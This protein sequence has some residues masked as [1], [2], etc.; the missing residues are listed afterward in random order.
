MYLGLKAGGSFIGSKSE[1]ANAPGVFPGPPDIVLKGRTFG[2]GSHTKGTFALGALMGYDFYSLYDK[3]VRL[4]LDYT[5]RSSVDYGKK[6]KTVL[7]ASVGGTSYPQTVDVDHKDKV[8]LQTLLLN[9]WFDI[10]NS[11]RVTPYIG[12]GLGMAHIDFSAR[13]RLAPARLPNSQT[14]VRNSK[15][16]TNLAWSLGTGLSFRVSKNVNLDLGYRYVYAGKAGSKKTFNFA[17]LRNIGLRSG[18]K[19]VAAHD[20]TFGFRYTF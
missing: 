4:E 10:K 2:L 5:F 7:D 16:A 12:G 13:E 8:R 19:K 17:G 1:I 20:V 14:I 9:I 11:S 3:P 15:R 6:T 18:V